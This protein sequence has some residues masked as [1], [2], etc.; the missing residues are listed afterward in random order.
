[1][2]P[3]K[4]SI[5]P[6]KHVRRKGAASEYRRARVHVDTGRADALRLRGNALP[7]GRLRLAEDGS[8]GGADAVA[9]EAFDEGGGV[10][11]ALKDGDD[12]AAKVALDFIGQVLGDADAGNVVVRAA[13][14]EAEEFE[15]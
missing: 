12:V 8:G 4:A 6:N 14:E 2:S 1:M 11:V 3:E 10:N 5:L 7:N 15:A 13:L 9:A